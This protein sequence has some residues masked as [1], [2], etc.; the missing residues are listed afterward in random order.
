[1]KKIKWKMIDDD[2][3]HAEIG[4]MLLSCDSCETL[5][6]QRHWFPKVYIKRLGMVSARRGSWRNSLAKAQ[7]DAIRLTEELLLDYHVFV[8]REL[9]ICEIEV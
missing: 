1:M 4:S 6:G 2:Y 8:S 9:R 7:E 3:C 5:T